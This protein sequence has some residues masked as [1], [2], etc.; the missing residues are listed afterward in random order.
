MLRI[1]PAGY[2]GASCPALTTLPFTPGPWFPPPP[3]PP[4]C[5]FSRWGNSRDFNINMLMDL[6]TAFDAVDVDGEKAGRIPV[7][8]WPH[9]R[10]TPSFSSFVC[11]PAPPGATRP[12]TLPGV[13]AASFTNSPLPLISCGLKFSDVVI[14]L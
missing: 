13:P 1:H 3:L 9:K 11:S 14:K 2:T 6:K 12:F 7:M 4:L 10:M 8:C 5:T